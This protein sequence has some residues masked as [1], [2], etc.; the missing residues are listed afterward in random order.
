LLSAIAAAISI[1]GLEIASV[2]WWYPFETWWYPYKSDM[3]LGF[4]PAIGGFLLG[5]SGV[6]CLLMMLEVTGFPS[7]KNWLGY[8]ISVGLICL[9][10]WFG[11]RGMTGADWNPVTMRTPVARRD[12]LR[13]YLGWAMY[14]LEQWLHPERKV[15]QGPD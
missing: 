5:I 3:P 13:E 11:G 12:V 9:S 4:Y 14:K 8:L 6:L 15:W 2:P 10:F 1:V 7:K